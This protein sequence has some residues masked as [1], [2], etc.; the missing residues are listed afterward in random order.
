MKK[1][2]FLK[3][4]LSVLCTAVLA[5]CGGSDDDTPSPTNTPTPTNT[6]TTTPT[7]TATPTASP[8]PT[9]PGGADLTD[10]ERQNRADQLAKA[11][12]AYVAIQHAKKINSDVD[13]KDGVANSNATLQRVSQTK[14]V[15]ALDTIVVAV[16]SND[17]GKV[18]YL[19]DFQFNDKANIHTQFPS[20]YKI[21][22][23]SS[24][25]NI[26][27]DIKSLT[28]AGLKANLTDATTPNGLLKAVNDA[29][30]GITAVSTASE[31]TNAVAKA[32]QILN[33]Y[34]DRTDIID[35]LGQDYARRL[36][37]A[38]PPVIESGLDA[39]FGGSGSDP[40]YGSLTSPLT[41]TALW[42]TITG[43]PAYSTISG[44]IT[45]GMTSD[46]DFKT[47]LDTLNRGT[48]GENIAN[49]KILNNANTKKLVENEINRGNSRE[50]E[51]YIKDRSSGTTVLHH[52]YGGTDRNTLGD[53]SNSE[54][55]ISTN[56]KSTFT[57][58]ESQGKRGGEGSPNENGGALVYQAGRRVY[59]TK[60]R[61]IDDAPNYVRT[62]D[63]TAN[64]YNNPTVTGVA[65]GDG[66]TNTTLA[67]NRNQVRSLEGSVAEVYGNKTF[68]YEIG[69]T[70]ASYQDNFVNDGGNNAPFTG[71]Y[72]KKTGYF[73]AKELKHVQYG[74]VTSAISGLQP[75][76]L[77]KG[78]VDNTVVGIYGKY[79][80]DGTENTY[81][82]RGNNRTS[83]ADIAKLS[84]TLK[85][86][87]HAVSYGLDNSFNNVTT[88]NSGIP[89]SVGAGSQGYQLWSGN[90]VEADIN[91]ADKTVKG[92]IYNI[93]SNG[94]KNRSGDLN[95]AKVELVNFNGDFGANGNMIGTSEVTK[96]TA[97]NQ[98]AALNKDLSDAERKGTFHAAL[99]GS[100][101]EEMAGNVK[102]SSN[103]AEKAWGASFGA[104]QVQGSPWAS[105]ISQ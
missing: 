18:T 90:H 44:E 100:N 47:K 104:A 98:S 32:K 75:S 70:N 74:R 91:T 23:N 55:R 24:Q 16:P 93:W 58:T 22:A 7:A 15:P 82:A 33:N 78:V 94:E 28:L 10:A 54:T 29:M 14:L 19:E 53:M 36:A 50:D 31:M 1:E 51:I 80:A 68:T 101:G 102:S 69:K 89:N 96:N 71:A 60:E 30:T 66:I 73:G 26:G 8:I 86:S 6:A 37:N 97:N 87:G 49:A 46:A 105:Q 56:G 67:N 64:F 27:Q 83:S 62:S 17:K 40:N 11:E 85:Y 99:F 61:N 39:S 57:E 76:D 92:S 9:T 2:K 4:G 59:V 42:S 79:G 77:K 13:E 34:A 20:T 63:Y 3:V 72:N 25:N 41:G 12:N 52:I 35:P 38:I 88:S 81:F 43:L 65:K 21:P 95:I 48:D 5:A 84:G 103:E 45:T